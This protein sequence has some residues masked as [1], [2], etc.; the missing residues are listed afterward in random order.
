MR[1]DLTLTFNNL[2]DFTEEVKA[3]EQVPTHIDAN[4]PGSDDVISDF[5]IIIKKNR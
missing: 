2:M 4:K 1:S 5:G 3:I